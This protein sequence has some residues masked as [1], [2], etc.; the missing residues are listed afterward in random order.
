MQKSAILFDSSQDLPAIEF[1]YD[2]FRFR[3]VR[4]WLREEPSKGT[5]RG[6]EKLS[7]VAVFTGNSLKLTKFLVEG[8]NELAHFFQSS[9]EYHM[10]VRS[11]YLMGNKLYDPFCLT[12]TLGSWLPLLK[13]CSGLSEYERAVYH[14]R[15]LFALMAKSRILENKLPSILLRMLR[16]VKWTEDNQKCWMNLLSTRAQLGQLP[17]DV[18]SVLVAHGYTHFCAYISNFSSVR[19]ALLPD[20]VV[21]ASL[22]MCMM[23]DKFEVM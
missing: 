10:R 11:Y 4:L 17:A 8:D 12:T 1:G 19:L 14:V 6:D 9:T 20:P 2:A 3:C 16:R 15:P 13:E 5:F 18:A 7:V 21:A 22:A 23:D